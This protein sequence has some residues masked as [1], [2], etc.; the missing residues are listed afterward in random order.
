MFISPQIS[1]SELAAVVKPR[2][3]RAGDLPAQELTER[4]P[5]LP[6]LE[7]QQILLR[8]NLSDWSLPVREE[9]LRLLL[10]PED[11][12]EPEAVH[13]VVDPVQTPG[14]PP[15]QGKQSPPPG[16]LGSVD[17]SLRYW[18]FTQ[19]IYQI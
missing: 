7:H 11:G 15:V 18:Q 8:H 17:V 2:E 1:W 16:N 10:G 9:L 13:L 12:V 19:E 6:G 14:E 5:A 3:G 4:S